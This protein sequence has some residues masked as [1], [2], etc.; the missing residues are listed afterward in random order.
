MTPKPTN[1]KQDMLFDFNQES[2]LL[3][4]GFTHGIVYASLLLWR[5]F[6][7]RQLSDRLLGILILV[8]C[9]HISH[10]MLGFAG[11]FNSHDAHTSF[12]FYF[13]IENLLLVGPLI[14]FYFRSL[15]NRG[16]R[17]AGR[18]W[19][20]FLPGFLH[21]GIYLTMF[22]VDVVV[23]HWISGEPLTCFYETKGYWACWYE[24]NLETTLQ[25]LWAV[26]LFCYLMATLIGYQ[27][28]RKYLNDHFSEQEYI[29][30]AWL[31]NLLIVFAVG[32]AITW[33]FDLVWIA[34]WQEIA[35]EL[36][37]YTHLVIAV[38][39]IFTGIQGY[40]HVKKLQ[41]LEFDGGRSSVG[42]QE[43]S[44]NGPTIGQEGGTPEQ[45]PSSGG[46]EEFRELKEKLIQYM[47]LEKPY[48]NPELK[49]KELSAALETNS[50]ILSKVINSGFQQNF[51]DFINSHRV[52]AVK[53]KLDD[54]ANARFSLL[55]IAEECGFNSKSTFNR[56]FK[57]FSG[58]SPREYLASKQPL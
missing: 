48:L 57:K 11:W 29:R 1:G 55:G 25:A 56:A 40:H 21:L 41:D 34:Y 44:T 28:Y 50:S 31:R 45:D 5:G 37:W 3:L 49:L 30:F 33:C 9:A 53:E 38:V 17:I 58:M 15:T 23:N 26:S 7:N 27:R 8:L 46:T 2:S 24:S 18:N 16:F 35:Y 32:V 10:Y 12:M 43:V 6:R 54:P 51:N 52:E 47:E 19:L 20:H 36:Y 22:L 42:T 14:Y 39:V 13:P 4:I